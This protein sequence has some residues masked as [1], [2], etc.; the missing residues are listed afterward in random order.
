MPRH[1]SKKENKGPNLASELTV[2]IVLICMDNDWWIYCEH[3]C[4]ITTTSYQWP[5][6]TLHRYSSQYNSQLKH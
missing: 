5:N 3:S 1:F 6:S 4:L 2:S